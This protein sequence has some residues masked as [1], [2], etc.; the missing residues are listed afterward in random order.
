M[1]CLPAPPTAHHL[2]NRLHGLLLENKLL[3]RHLFLT[4]LVSIFFG[5][6]FTLLF[7]LFVELL[8]FFSMCLLLL[9]YQSHLVASSLGLEL[10][11]R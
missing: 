1:D 4:R 11:L 10:V 2:R 5:A 9:E 6:G 3:L 8:L 7:R